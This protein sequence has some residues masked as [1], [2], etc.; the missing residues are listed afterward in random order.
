MADFLTRLAE[1]ALGVAPTAQ[2]RVASL[3][4]PGP[5][6]ASLFA[7]GPRVA[8][9]AAESAALSDESRVM[10]G[11]RILLAD[12]RVPSVRSPA[13]AH[14]SSTVLEDSSPVGPQQAVRD[15]RDTM[16]SPHPMNQLSPVDSRADEGPRPE[17]KPFVTQGKPVSRPDRETSGP[18]GPES[19]GSR[20]KIARIGSQSVPS[21]RKPITLPS[22]AARPVQR[23]EPIRRRDPADSVTAPS[24]SP[25]VRVTIGRVEVRAILPP[26]PPAARTAAVRSGPAP[27]L[28]EYL[29]RP[30]GERR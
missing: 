23:A 27:S 16:P 26:P 12:D 3:F 18:R 28:E 24:P 22:Q 25:T 7:T 8:V 17:S 10:S 13:I 30:N 29:K 14:V 11:D 1:R 15:A 6:V 5:R 2:P 4:D 20:S 9:D 21:S 19:A